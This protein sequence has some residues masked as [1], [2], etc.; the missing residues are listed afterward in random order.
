[1][2]SKGVFNAAKEAAMLVD[3]GHNYPHK[4]GACIFKGSKIIST[5]KNYVRSC[6]RI[7][8]IYLKHPYTLH[9]EQNAVIN[10]PIGKSLK[11]CSIFVI[12]LTPAGNLS[13]AMP[14]VYCMDTLRYKGIRKVFFT[15]YD[16][17]IELFK[18]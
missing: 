4:I 12:R 10:A 15:N 9:A 5:G 6:S 17:D 18:L 13:M 7:K 11:G 3:T 2:I 14:C 8:D 16:G 1:M